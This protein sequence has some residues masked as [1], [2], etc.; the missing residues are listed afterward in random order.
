MVRFTVSNSGSELTAE[1]M[2][3]VFTPFWRSDEARARDQEGSGLGLAI[4][5]QLVSLHGGQLGVT[6]QPGWTHF[7][8]EVP[9]VRN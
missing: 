3:Q 5:Q 4:A 9:A 8:F 2:T 1:E 7:Y 6:S